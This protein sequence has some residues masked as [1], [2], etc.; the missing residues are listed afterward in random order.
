MT[1]Q[2]LFL[3]ADEGAQSALVLGGLVQGYVVVHLGLALR[4]VR[5]HR[6][7]L[8]LAL[9]VVVDGVGVGANNGMVRGQPSDLDL[10]VL[11]QLQ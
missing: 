4:D 10:V 9:G 3:G 11:L 2:V 7:L 6:A 1:A 8:L 5:T